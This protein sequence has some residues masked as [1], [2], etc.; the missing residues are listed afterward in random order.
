MSPCALVLPRIPTSCS[1]GLGTGT[2]LGPLSP[3]GGSQGW[4]LPG[5]AAPAGTLG[6]GGPALPRAQPRLCEESD[7]RAWASTLRTRDLRAGEG[8]ALEGDICW[9]S[10]GLCSST[11]ATLPFSALFAFNLSLPDTILLLP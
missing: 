6:T 1:L 7:R 8:R 2:N 3:K 4:Q 10:L 9:L 11:Q 5:L